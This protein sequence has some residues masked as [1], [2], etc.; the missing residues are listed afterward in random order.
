MVPYVRTTDGTLCKD[1]WMVPY[2]RTTDGT[3]M[4]GLLHSQVSIQNMVYPLAASL[5]GIKAAT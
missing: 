1:Y 5:P 3:L 4:Y 2:V